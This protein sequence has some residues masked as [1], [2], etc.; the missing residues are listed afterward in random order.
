MLILGAQ[1]LASSLLTH[2]APTRQHYEHIQ[3]LLTF[4]HNM[5][6]ATASHEH[7]TAPKAAA[8]APESKSDVR[9]SENNTQTLPERS[10][11]AKAKKEKVVK[12]PKGPMPSKQ[13]REPVTATI[14]N[15]PD[16]M[17]KV[18]FLADVY[19]ERPIGSGGISK[20]VTRCESSQS[21]V[22]KRKTF[23]IH[24]IQS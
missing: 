11:P 22:H 24:K 17:F 14:P 21:T 18:G 6:T 5:D 7:A 16:S 13:K 23:D 1:T 8:Q 10:K 9:P 19:Q 20:V 3:L 15:D 2:I 4:E 12:P